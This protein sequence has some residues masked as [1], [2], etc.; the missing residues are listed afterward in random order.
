MSPLEEHE[1]S[2][3]QEKH[4]HACRRLSQVKRKVFDSGKQRATGSD[5]NLNDVRKVEKEREKVSHSFFLTA[6]Q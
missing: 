3:F 2:I 4:Q 1:W 6:T 5:V